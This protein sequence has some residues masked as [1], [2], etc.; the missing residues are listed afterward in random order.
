MARDLPAVFRG[1]NGGKPSTAARDARGRFL[2]GSAGGG[3]PANPFGRYQR[4]LRLAL[5]A[6]VTPTTCGLSS[7]RW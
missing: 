4:E 1:E 2:P 7:R 5:V 6:E 3:R